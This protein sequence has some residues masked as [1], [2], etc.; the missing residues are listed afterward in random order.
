MNVI[1]FAFTSLF[2]IFVLPKGLFCYSVKADTPKLK[3]ICGARL[4]I[5]SG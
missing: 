4:N 5:R 1:S 3:H 2:V